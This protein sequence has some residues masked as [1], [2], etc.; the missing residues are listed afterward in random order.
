MTDVLAFKTIRVCIVH[1]MALLARALGAALESERSISIVNYS[2]EVTDPAI[3]AA[4]AD[5]VLLDDEDD[6]AVLVRHVT[7]IKERTRALLCILSS[8]GHPSRM[9]SALRAGADGY[10]LKDTTVKASIAAI[11]RLCSERVY[12]EPR[13]ALALMHGDS[14]G[15]EEL[16]PRER[17][18]AELVARGLSNRAVAQTLNISEKTVKNYVSTILTKL[19]ARRRT[20]IVIYAYERGWPHGGVSDGGAM[21]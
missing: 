18:V 2:T 11:H 14:S 3:V 16:S 5:V 20:E 10:L 8:R 4:N 15:E 13:I 7:T 12:I 21:R 17:Q 1:P 6:T 19:D 9:Q